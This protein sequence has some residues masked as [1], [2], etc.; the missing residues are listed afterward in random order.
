MSNQ[1]VVVLSSYPSLYKPGKGGIVTLKYWN[2][3][4]ENGGIVLSLSD[5]LIPDNARVK[6]QVGKE[7]STATKLQPFPV[8]FK[9]TVAKLTG[10]CSFF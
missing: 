3:W 8:H 4:C 5:N 6:K 10:L 7:G 9:N 2:H 1:A